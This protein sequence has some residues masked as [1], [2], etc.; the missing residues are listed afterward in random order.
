[1]VT[2]LVVLPTA[3]S[4]SVMSRTLLG[5]L[6]HLGDAAGVVG[7][8]AVGVERDHDAGHAEHGGGGDRDAV[9]AGQR[10]RRP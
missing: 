7:D 4:G 9:Q 10:S 2:A 3:S 8:G 6:G 1:L 5:Q